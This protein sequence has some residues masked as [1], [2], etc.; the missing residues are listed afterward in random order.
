M[1]DSKQ[2]FGQSSGDTA[3]FYLCFVIIE[4]SALIVIVYNF[5]NLISLFCLSAIAFIEF[6]PIN[7][8]FCVVDKTVGKN[9]YS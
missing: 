5:F 2:I 3:D 6:L 1:L 8:S 4:L 7:V 9:I